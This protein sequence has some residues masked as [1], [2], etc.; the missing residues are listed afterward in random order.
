ML[1]ISGEERV[2]GIDAPTLKEA[3]I[4][5]VSPTGAGSWPRPASPTSKP[6]DR[7]AE[8]MHATQEWKD[9]LSQNGWTDAFV[10]GR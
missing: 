4:D 8:E 9:A 2:D 7:R 6:P 5:L 10:T 3:G 1:A